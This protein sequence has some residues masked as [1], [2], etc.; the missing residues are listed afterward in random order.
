MRLPAPATPWGRRGFYW[1]EHQAQRAGWHRAKIT[2][3]ECPRISAAWLE[4]ERRSIGPRAF[5]QE[6]L[7]EFVEVEDQVFSY[8]VIQAAFAD[9]FPPLFPGLSD[10]DD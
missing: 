10:A 6:Y 4:E 7:C 1:E 9:D 2:A 8:D 3:P 5:A